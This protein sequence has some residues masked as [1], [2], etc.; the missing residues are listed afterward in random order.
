MKDSGAWHGS[1][2][3]RTAGRTFLL[4]GFFAAAAAAKAQDSNPGPLTP[5]PGEE[6]RV[7][8]LGTKPIPEGPPALPPEE[9]IR[10]FAQKEDEYLEATSH[11]RFRKVIRLQEFNSEGK[12]TGEERITI[13][14][15]ESASGRL[16]YKITR[17]GESALQNLRVEPEEIQAV[18]RVQAYP[19]LTRELPRY[20]IRYAGKEQV[21]EI[22]CYLFEVHPKAVDRAHPAFD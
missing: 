16:R 13:E 17:E 5:P 20:N 2:R 4:A 9:I 10:R 21:D 7:R 19:L 14:P 1:K 8:R 22:S 6:H 12:P 15:V 18:A 11:F 3:L